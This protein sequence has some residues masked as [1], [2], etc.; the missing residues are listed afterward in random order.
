MMRKAVRI[1]RDIVIAV[2]VF[3]LA[4]TVIRQALW[5]MGL[6]DLY[7]NE[8]MTSRAAEKARD[9]VFIG[10]SHL[11]VGIHP[12]TFDAAATAHGLA[13]RSFDLALGGLSVAETYSV[14][15]RLFELKPCCIKYVVF[16]AAFMQ[17]DIGWYIPTNIRS[18]LYLDFRNA[19]AFLSMIFS[20]EQLPNPAPGRWKYVAN[21]VSAMATHYGNL[22][23]AAL[24]LGWGTT[25]LRNHRQVDFGN[26]AAHLPP[27]TE[28]VAV[29][30]ARDMRRY[31][32]DHPKY[33]R[34]E[35]AGVRRGTYVTA[36]MLDPVVATVRLIESKGAG[37]ILVQ[38]PLVGHWPYAVDFVDA[39]RRRCGGERLIDFS[40]PEE[41][42]EFYHTTSYW[43]DGSHLSEEGAVIWSKMLA[44]R[45]VK[46]VET[47]VA[48]GRP[49]SACP[50]PARE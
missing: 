5:R 31:S 34:G 16:E 40:D 29:A 28:A 24:L 49:T 37:V 27:P 45:F 25:P 18:V 38:P 2:T 46:I 23:H 20:Y 3:L 22:G 14:A 19:V 41:F 26:G 12:N 13:P 32:V 8:V 48:R 35:M 30:I 47:D 11:G 1:A 50:E 9:V 6:E 4:S 39:L 10:T 15:K 36:R 17:T 33:R 7:V 44:A 42:R 43:H 21:V